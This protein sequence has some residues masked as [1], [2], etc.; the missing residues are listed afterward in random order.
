MNLRTAFAILALSTQAGVVCAQLIDSPGNAA[1][2]NLAQIR[3]M[4]DRG[5]AADA[6]KQLDALTTQH[7]APAGVDRG[8]RALSAAGRAPRGHRRGRR[9]DSGSAW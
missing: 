7:P 4:I 6:L 2:P 9:R 3:Q 5:R 8:A 1:A